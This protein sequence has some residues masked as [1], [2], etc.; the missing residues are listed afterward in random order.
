MYKRSM[1]NWQ[2]GHFFAGRCT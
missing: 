2:R 1:C